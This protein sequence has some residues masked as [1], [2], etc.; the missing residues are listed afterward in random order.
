MSEQ[1]ADEIKKLLSKSEGNENW[2]EATEGVQM[3]LRADKTIWKV[4]EVPAFKADVR[5]L[6][7][8]ELLINFANWCCELEWDGQVFDQREQT[9]QARRFGPAQHYEDLD[10]ALEAA[11]G[12]QEDRSAAEVSGARQTHGSCGHHLRTK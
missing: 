6:G 7:Q 11:L 2:G 3:R 12:Q 1:A 4:G 5:N 10:I 8:R 9:G